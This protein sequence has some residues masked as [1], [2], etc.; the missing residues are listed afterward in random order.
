VNQ[1]NRSRRMQSICVCFIAVALVAS[2]ALASTAAAEPQGI[3]KVYK[4]CPTEKS[5][6]ALCIYGETT[7]GEFVIGSTK[8]PINK[9]LLLQAG[10]VHTGGSNFNEYRFVPPK[11][12]ETM[13]KTELN[14][15]GGLAGLIN[16][17]EIKG[18]GLLEVTERA[19]C[20]LV[21]ENGL[22]GVTTTTEYVGT[23]SNPAILNFTNIVEEK[24]TGLSLPIRAHLKNPLLGSNC[25]IGSST[26]PI[27]LQLTDGTTSPPEPN[28]PI[29]GKLGNPT[30]E[31]EDEF[32]SLTTTENTLVDNSFSVPV[33]E[34]CGGLASSLLD[35]I[36]DAKLG[37]ESPAGHNTAIL[38]S[39]LHNAESEAVVASEK[40]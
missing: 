8:V 3:F 13:S 6:V 9:T 25:Y 37:L 36:V 10:A 2:L 39:T 26:H 32:E 14:V 18:G 16:C 24:R 15:P 12:G 19:A 35:P 1:P 17:E 23:T 30:T 5:E 31:V 20:K 27:Q 29:S 38:N 28:K 33:V 7:S 21:F 11:G 34:G 4:D 40:F 22:T